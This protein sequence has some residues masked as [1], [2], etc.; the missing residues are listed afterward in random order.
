MSSASQYTFPLNP[1]SAQINNHVGATI[2]IYYNYP[3]SSGATSNIRSQTQPQAAPERTSTT[4]KDP[5]SPSRSGDMNDEAARTNPQ[6]KGKSRATD[7]LNGQST[8]DTHGLQDWKLIS[9]YNP[10]GIISSKP[11]R[12]IEIEDER[13]AF[14]ALT[15]SQDVAS[16][17]VKALCDERDYRDLAVTVTQRRDNIRARRTRIVLES[18][19][20]EAEL[21]RLGPD[22]AAQT[23]DIAPDQ[24]DRGEALLQRCEE[25][26]QSRNEVEAT[27][28]QLNQEIEEAPKTWRTNW[29]EVK[30]L[31]DPVWVNADVF[32]PRPAESIGDISERLDD[33]L[34]A[35]Q[36]SPK[37]TNPLRQQVAQAAN[38]LQEARARFEDFCYNY[39][40][41]DPW[42]DGVSPD[43][44]D[45][46]DRLD[47]LDK[48]QD[49]R[50]KVERAK[51]NYKSAIDRAIQDGIDRG[52]LDVVPPEDVQSTTSSELYRDDATYFRTRPIDRLE[53]WRRGVV[54]RTPS[55]TPIRAVA[56]N[57]C[58]PDIEH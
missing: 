12:L 47:F 10:D 29:R 52:T 13:E 54:N 58:D 17:L 40:T 31:L 35:E 48:L 18:E 43:H 51:S 33:S 5:N 16:G 22:L 42:K 45:Q 26:K 32:I 28:L 55:E 2:D 19:K 50:N 44:R 11:A 7:P 57:I 36:L 49:G 34:A 1:G 30:R 4:T 37:P 3:P 39:D 6:A 53:E 56:D 21:R 24:K 8:R 15:L 41:W 25:L 14:P 9:T 38:V 46:V 20:V 27:R 23:E